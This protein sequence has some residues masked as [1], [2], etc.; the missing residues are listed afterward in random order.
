MHL[1]R[2]V[3]RV[4]IWQWYDSPLKTK[5]VLPQLNGSMRTSPERQR[6]A[7][8]SLAVLALAAACRQQGNDELFPVLVTGKAVAPSKPP[9]V[10]PQRASGTSGVDAEQVREATYFIT[11]AFL[12]E[13][14]LVDSA[15]ARRADTMTVISAFRADGTSLIG[16]SVRAQFLS[17]IVGYLVVDDADR[18]SLRRRYVPAYA[19]SVSERVAKRENGV[20][21]MVDV[22]GRPFVFLNALAGNTVLKFSAEDQ[23]RIDRMIRPGS[24]T[25]R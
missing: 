12:K 25:G 18:T 14:M 4:R 20:W 21:R 22:P 1:F 10:Q 3:D 13:G 19:S 17:E 5:N 24:S 6:L 11:Q 7:R 23:K 9:I 15:R 2:A 8:V 16:D